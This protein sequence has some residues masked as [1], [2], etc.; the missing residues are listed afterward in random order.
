MHQH[1]NKTR[2]VERFKKEMAVVGEEKKEKK[3]NLR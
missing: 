1:D 3:E 2:E